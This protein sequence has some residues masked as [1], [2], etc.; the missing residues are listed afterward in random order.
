MVV[1]R[2]YPM[3]LGRCT[4]ASLLVPSCLA[5]LFLH[6]AVNIHAVV[7]DVMQYAEVHPQ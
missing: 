2:S 4:G 3:G 6:C 5:G 7:R 1:P